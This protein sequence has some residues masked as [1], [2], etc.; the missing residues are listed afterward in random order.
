MRQPTPV[1]STA[2]SVSVLMPMWNAAR[3]VH[4]AVDSLLAQTFVDFELVVVDDGSTD[5]SVDIVS[6]VNDPRVRLVKSTHG[7][8]AAALNTGLVHCRAPVVARMDADDCCVPERLAVQ[9]Q[10]LSTCDIVCSR[11]ELES[12]NASIACGMARYVAWQNR[13]LSHEA[14]YLERYIESPLVHP[15]IMARR[16]WYEAGYRTDGVPEDYALFL[17]WFAAGARFYKCEQPLVQWFDHGARATR[18]QVTYSKDSHRSLKVEWLMADLLRSDSSVSKRRAMFIGAGL[19]A[20][21][22]MRALHERGVD[23][24]AAADL[25]PGRV[26]NIIHGAKVMDLASLARLRTDEPVFVAI[27]VPSARAQVRADVRRLGWV[28]GRDFWCVC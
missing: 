19:E 5:D 16:A 21:P 8:V 28:E 18:T 11:V 4:R 6:G 14:M 24:V 23:I 22:L 20:K 12:D 7:G 26:G 17:R 9:Y 27:G 15:T 1:S 13:L 2:P 25:H 3:T 10:A